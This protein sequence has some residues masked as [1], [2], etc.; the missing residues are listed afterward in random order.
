MIKTYEITIRKS[1]AYIFN[2]IEPIYNKKIM[3]KIATLFI[4]S[5]LLVSFCALGQ[6]RQKIGSNDTNIAVSATLELE[7]TTTGFLPPRMTHQ[8]RNA[9]VSP[10]AGLIVWCT[11]CSSAGELQ[12]Y[13]GTTW[14]NII[15]G[16]A[17]FAVPDAPTSPIATAGNTQASVAFTAPASNGGSAITS[18]TVTSSPGGFTASGASSPLTVT[19]LTNGTAYTFTVTA[20]NVTGSSLASTA[21]AAVTPATVP[22]APTSPIATAG[23]TQASV[24]FTTPVSDGGSAV[25]AYTVTASPGGAIATGTTSPL[26]VTGLTNGTAYTFT[27]IATNAVGNSL[28]STA[29][30]AVT[31]VT[32]PGAPT[33]PIATAGNTQASVA[34]TA[35][36]SNG[37]SA[38]TSYTVTSSPGN[39]T[40]TGTTSPIRITGLTSGTSYTFT[41][42]A[43]NAVGS[44][45]ASAASTS[46][47]TIAA[48]GAA[49]CN[50]TRVTDIVEFTSNY[51]GK[52]WMDRNLGASRVG[53]SETDHFAYGCLY[54]WG[55]GN[56]GHASITW[57]SGYAGTPVNAIAISTQV[58]TDTPENTTFIVNNTDWRS[59]NNNNLWQGVNGINNPCPSGFRVPTNQ[60]WRNE[61]DSSGYNTSTTTAGFSSPFKFVLSGSR[62]FS[63]AD[64]I[65]IGAEVSIWSST[66][67]NQYASRFFISTTTT[68]AYSVIGSSRSAG[69]PVRCIK[70]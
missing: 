44:S 65:T 3:K 20:T 18:Y 2:L 45:S 40:A 4:P 62:Q 59:P 46:V 14:T 68:L 49:V 43:T 8:Q 10:V 35:P 64:L 26:T 34:F 16:A 47:A 70:D 54:Q 55:R 33:S 56:D 28:A 63:S 38:I 11:N 17:S 51:T 31:P 58:A 22:D 57:T 53:S 69:F 36:V 66:T 13:N 37:G 25:T 30:A 41:V 21:S 15:G 32:V 50:G 12:V 67:I 42:T 27:V 24:A 19:G 1:A 52:V 29:S 61:L 7:S 5:M 9:I 39:F 6:M 48:S 23:N 60:E